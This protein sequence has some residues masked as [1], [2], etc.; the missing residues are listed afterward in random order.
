[1]QGIE[2]DP[3]TLAS[4]LLRQFPEWSA[5]ELDAVIEQ[6]PDIVILDVD[7]ERDGRRA[8]HQLQR[9][10]EATEVERGVPAATIEGLKSRGHNVAFRP[11]PLGGGQAIVI[12]W[13]R[14]VLIAGSEPRKDGC[15]L[16][17]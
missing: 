14:G 13:D 10:A 6:A 16:G 1:M 5:D 2:T 11:A 3:K 17:Y 4:D 7:L 15:A 8:V 9:L 12:D